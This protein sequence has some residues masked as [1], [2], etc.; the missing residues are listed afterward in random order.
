MSHKEDRFTRKCAEVCDEKGIK[1]FSFDL[2]EH[3]DRKQQEPELTIQQAIIEMKSIMEY[4]QSKYSKI[5][6]N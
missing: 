3:G 5:K 6:T 2:P 1:V 4:L